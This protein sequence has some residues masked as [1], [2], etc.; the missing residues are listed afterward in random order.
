ML[1]FIISMSWDVYSIAVFRTA[2]LLW[3]MEMIIKLT[4]AAATINK[5][6]I[7]ISPCRLFA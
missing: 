7:L 5:R 2:V 3:V 4:T 1:S 6:E